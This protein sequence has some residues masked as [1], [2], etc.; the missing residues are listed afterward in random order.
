MKFKALSTFTV[1]HNDAMHVF[2]AGKSGELPD[3][4]VAEYV[5]AGLAVALKGK[6]AKV[7][8]DTE[9]KPEDDDAVVDGD[10]AAENGDAP[11]VPVADTDAPPA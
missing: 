3:A 11:A 1:F 7:E 5:T 4:V 6:A 8:P 2:N 9:Q 10:G